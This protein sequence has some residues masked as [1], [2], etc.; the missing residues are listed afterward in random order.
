MSANNRRDGLDR[1]HDAYIEHLKEHRFSESGRALARWVLPLFFDYLRGRRI[2][3]VRAVTYEHLASFV[4]LMRAKRTLRG[5][6]YSASTHQMQVSMVK[7]FF[8]YLEKRRLLLHNAAQDLRVPIARRL[9]RGVI[10]QTQAR[11]LMNAPSLWSAMGKRDKAVLEVLYGCGLRSRECA[12]VNVA[13]VS[14][15]QKTLW[16]RD[17]KGHKDRLVPL[18]HQTCRAL[19]LYLR[20]GRPEIVMDPREDALFLSN[21][22]KRLLDG[23]VRLVVKTYAK[24]L[25]L[26]ELSSHGLR[27]A[28][29]THLLENGADV[30]HVQKILGHASIKT[31][32]IYTRVAIGDLK[33]VLGRAHPRE[34]GV[35]ARLLD[36]LK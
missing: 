17:G 18:P 11:K 15:E 24:S 2:K 20:E 34:K 32:A 35:A 7:R 26:A 1:L 23:G 4:R 6:E 14:L 25:G 33:A 28:C 16:V 19:T 30:R 36:R 5:K 31:T 3:D 22:R 9:P 10:S 29:A 12:R 21:A 13:D 8:R 27:H